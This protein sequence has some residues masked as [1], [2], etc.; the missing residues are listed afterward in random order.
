MQA[1]LTLT[2]GSCIDLRCAAKRAHGNTAAVGGKWNGTGGGLPS[3]PP[4]KQQVRSAGEHDDASLV[5]ASLLWFWFTRAKSI[6]WQ[7]TGRE[8]RTYPFVRHC[9]VSPCVQA[10]PR[11]KG[12]GGSVV[13]IH[14]HRPDPV[15][16][17]YAYVVRGCVHLSPLFSSPDHYTWIL[18]ALP[19]IELNEFL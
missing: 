2:A 9:L 14:A 16:D 18:F 12:C 6:K 15:P 7:H 4:H 10:L 17:S 3:P 8:R 11:T 5:C 13:P 19:T 1:P